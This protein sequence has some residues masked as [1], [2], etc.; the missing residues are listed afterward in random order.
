MTVDEVRAAL[1]LATD[2]ELHDLTELLFRPKFNP[3]DYLRLPDPID[4]Q[5]HDRQQWITELEERFCY[6]AAD[7]LTVLSRKTRHLTYRQVLIQ[8][9]RYLR[10]PYKASMSTTAL[11]EEIF[12]TV[13]ARAWKQLPPAEQ[14]T[15]QIR[16][17]RSLTQSQLLPELPLAAQ[18]DPIG[19][20]LKGSTALAVTSVVRPLL[21]K[22]IAQQFALHFA[23]YHVAQQVLAKGGAIAAAQVQQ[24]VM[25]QTARRGMALSAARYTATRSLF[26][27]LGPAMWMLFFAD[28]GWRAISTNYGRIIPAV[29][30]LAQIRLIRAE[31]FELAEAI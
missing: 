1:E 25:L 15:L 10:L 28:L 5:S 12:L 9:C 31:C 21:L 6:L 11:E 7:G 20:V 22:L 8:V 14:G 17:R 3:L 19:L 27:F 24:Y 18:Q 2:E 23:R 16:L 13:L 29:Y 4:I 30:A 26:A